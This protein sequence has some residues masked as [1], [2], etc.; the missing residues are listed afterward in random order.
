MKR[1]D[2]G[3]KPTYL[4]HVKYPHTFC[5]GS[6]HVMWNTTTP[7]VKLLTEIPAMSKLQTLLAR[8]ENIPDGRWHTYYHA[9]LTFESGVQHSLFDLGFVYHIGSRL[10]EDELPRPRFE[11]IPIVFNDGDAVLQ[12][13]RIQRSE[14]V[15]FDVMLCYLWV[16]NDTL[17]PW[18]ARCESSGEPS[19]LCLVH[20]EISDD[21]KKKKRLFK[22][23]Q[24]CV[25]VSYWF[26]CPQK[27][28]RHSE[29]S[30]PFCS[31]RWSWRW[32][33]VEADRGRKKGWKV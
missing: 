7:S 17:L 26:W 12:K 10:R 21:V 25:N 30:C 24:H 8:Y 32:A 23:K 22:R 6:S 28:E 18:C 1:T 33:S 19:C 5:F 16:R 29:D 2:E 31:W 14:W 4:L 3:V 15:V 13:H 27:V 9:V 20:L 11:T